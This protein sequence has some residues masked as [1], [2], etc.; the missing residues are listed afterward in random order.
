MVES[1]QQS[2]LTRLY[3][4]GLTRQIRALSHRQALLCSPLVSWCTTK[5]CDRPYEEDETPLCFPEK[6]IRNARNDGFLAEYWCE[7][8]GRRWRE[9]WRDH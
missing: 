4:D 2:A 9:E 1:K 7:E 3:Q 8:C 6:V 5:T